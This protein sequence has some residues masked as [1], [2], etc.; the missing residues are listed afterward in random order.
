ME[1][2]A[3]QVIWSGAHSFGHVTTYLG[4]LAA[5]LGLD[6]RAD[7]YFASA[8]ELQEREGMMLWAARAHLGWGEALGRRGEADRARAEIT[9]ALELARQHGYGAIERR[10]AAQVETGSVAKG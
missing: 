1:P 9:R 5:T 8:C 2:W 3:G 7:E 6:E 4:L 10:A